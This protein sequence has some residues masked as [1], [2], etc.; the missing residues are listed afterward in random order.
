MTTEVTREQLTQLSDD[1][2][3]ALPGDEFGTPLS[4]TVFAPT[5]MTRGS[6]SRRSDAT[7]RPPLG[8]CIPSCSG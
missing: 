6:S 4:R 5:A 3:Q 1:Q 2:L 7:T 8:P